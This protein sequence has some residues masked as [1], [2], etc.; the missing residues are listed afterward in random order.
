MHPE[1]KFILESLECGDPYL[2]RNFIG[3]SDAPIIMGLSP[4]RTAYELY[5]E[6]L[7]LISSQIE[8]N[9]MRD[10][11]IKEEH[12]RKEFELIKGLTFPSKRLFSSDYEW[13]MASIDGMSGFGDILEIKCP[14]EV[15]YYK[16]KKEGIPEMYVCQMQH[17][18]FVSNTNICYYFCY[19]NDDEHHTHVVKRDNNYI[20]DIVQKE[21]E[22]WNCVKNMVPPELNEK[23]FVVRDD[24]EFTMV[25][26]DI[27]SSRQQIKYYT[28]RLKLDEERLIKLCGGKNTKGAGI[29]VTKVLRKGNIDYT[30]VEELKDVD[31]EKYRKENSEYWKISLTEKE[32]D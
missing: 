29:K 21:V 20:Q 22:F 5:Q 25:S 3:A 9:Y 12:A 18:M 28:D 17:Q 2:R 32:N 30:K 16:S 31:L 23:D 19:L 13:M 27:N 4:W 1:N 8:N 11:K 24:F 10:G 7:G 6:K 26:M 14:G 15:S